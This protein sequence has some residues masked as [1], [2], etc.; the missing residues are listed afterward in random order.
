ML[1]LRRSQN[2]WQHI[3]EYIDEEIS[4]VSRNIT[5]DTPILRRILR[6]VQLTQYAM[7]PQHQVNIRKLIRECF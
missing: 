1:L 4:R 5:H 2:S 7:L 6:I 3:Q